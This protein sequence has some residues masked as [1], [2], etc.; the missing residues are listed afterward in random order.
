MFVTSFFTFTTYMLWVIEP[1][2]ARQHR[3]R[4]ISVVR[5]YLASGT[6]LFFLRQVLFQSFEKFLT[7]RILLDC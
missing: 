6:E 5:G 2:I 3:L 7:Q 4:L 1:K